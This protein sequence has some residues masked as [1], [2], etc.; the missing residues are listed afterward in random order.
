MGHMGEG[1]TKDIQVGDTYMMQTG[2]TGMC[3]FFSLVK[4]RVHS[5]RFTCLDQEKR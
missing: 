1:G 4:K 5:P 2:E 3:H